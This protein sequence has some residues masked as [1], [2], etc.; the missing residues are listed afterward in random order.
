LSR[1]KLTVW[2][3]ESQ[4]SN[5]YDQHKVE[6]RRRW[7]EH[8]RPSLMMQSLAA[9]RRLTLS[10]APHDAEYWRKRAK[11]T[12]ALAEQMSTAE[13][14]RELLSIAKAYER[15]AELASDKKS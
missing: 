10:T 8:P 2:L 13:D 6:F 12:L 11:E 15:L 14:K 5:E 3:C 4:S 9:C 1:Q 7:N